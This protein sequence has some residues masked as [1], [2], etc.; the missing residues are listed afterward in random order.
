MSRHI[1]VLLNESIE[2]L[3]I[4]PEGIYV[5]GTFGAGGH[6]KLILS[7]LTSG[8]LYAFD[9]DPESYEKLEEHFKNDA[10]FTMIEKNF[11]TLKQ[12]LNALN[13]TSIDGILLDLGMSSM[14]IDQ[15]SRG[16]SYIQEGPLDMR[17][18]PYQSLT[19]SD[20]LNTYELEDLTKI[21]IEYGEVEHPYKVAK[22]LMAKR[23]YHT[24]TDL[25]KVTDYLF[26]NSKGH[27]A[28]KVFQALRIA[29]NDELQALKEVLDQAISLLNPSGRLVVITF[30]SLE[31]RI[32]KHVMMRESKP[33]QIKGLPVLIEQNMA[34]KLISNK[35]ILPS[36][37]EIKF[38]SRSAS[39]KLR[40]A[41]KQ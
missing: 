27:S 25:V 24:T 34:L 4:K 38:N 2:A 33:V 29:V 21:L 22:T 18:N 11:R 19:A 23:P 6:S 5:D 16:F 14:H 28:K 41:E 20:I 1:S 9:Q 12:S 40:V 15:A 8:Q 13:V 35:P 3:N 31:D 10:R 17:M 26:K 37:E 32:V 39:A 36:E 30:H 7:H